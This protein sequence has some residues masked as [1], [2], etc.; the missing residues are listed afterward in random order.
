MGADDS[1]PDKVEDLKKSDS[2]PS[3]KSPE[4][5]VASLKEEPAKPPAITDMFEVEEEEIVSMPAA[6]K[7]KPEA[8]RSAAPPKKAPTVETKVE[9]LKLD[10]K[11]QSSKEKDDKKAKK[12]KTDSYSDEWGADDDLDLED[13]GPD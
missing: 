12:D 11:K 2:E 5:Q 1:K 7:N 9:E 10:D 3:R 13:K 6:K 4:K 8:V